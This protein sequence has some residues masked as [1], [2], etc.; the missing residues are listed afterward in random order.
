MTPIL[1]LLAGLSFAQ[2]KTVSPTDDA[3]AEAATDDAS[4]AVPAGVEEGSVR[5]VH[6]VKDGDTID[7]IALDYGF[8]PVDLRGWN[9]LEGDVKAGDEVVLWIPPPEPESEAETEVADAAP[10]KEKKEKTQR[11]AND[12]QGIGGFVGAHVG[13]A[14]SLSPLGTAVTPRI[15]GG[16]ILPM[17]DRSFRIFVGGQYLK[18]VASGEGQDPHVTGGWDY[19]MKQDELSI[20]FGVGF[21]PGMIDGKIKPE[22]SVGPNIYLYRS[23]V[24][25]SAGGAAFPETTEQYTRVGI[26]ASGGASMDLG[27]GEL[28]VLLTMASSGL[29]GVVTGEAASAALSPSLGY[30]LIF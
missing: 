5:K 24:N 13:P 27:P 26:Y 8:M 18:P 16:I 11:S 23:T 9:K 30:R 14:F 19:E 25:G 3:K 21:R 20:S 10:T 29:N 4:A 17:V 12:N 28:A 2:D 6:T 22:V 1:L 15:E 7:S